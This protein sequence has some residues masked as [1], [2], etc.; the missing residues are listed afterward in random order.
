M[1]APGRVRPL[2]P[3]PLGLVSRALAAGAVATLLVALAAPAPAAACPGCFPADAK[4]QSAYRAA[5][6]LLIAMPLAIIGAGGA[7]LAL[8]SRRAGRRAARGAVAG[9]DQP[10]EPGRG[11]EIRSTR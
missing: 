11:G 5:T 8:A 9:A 3:A 10:R 7:W 6:L 1:R 2:S 4:S